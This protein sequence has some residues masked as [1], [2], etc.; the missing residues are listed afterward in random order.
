MGNNVLIPLALMCRIV[1]LLEY[2][3][4]SNYDVVIQ[5]ERLDVLNA[6]HLKKRKLELREDYSKIVFAKNEDDR[7][8]ARINYLQNR[9][10][11]RNDERSLF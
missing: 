8:N 3:D 11:L 10:C 6:L 5:H 9:S 4:A 7:L 2:W 1:E